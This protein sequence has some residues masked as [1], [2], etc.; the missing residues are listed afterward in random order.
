[1]RGHHN[2]AKLYSTDDTYGEFL[3]LAVQA[4]DEWAAAD[5]LFRLAGIEYEG[6]DNVGVSV[7][8]CLFSSR[9]SFL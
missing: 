3:N 1:M 2:I 6:V 9:A 4:Q 8:L 7:V 5:K